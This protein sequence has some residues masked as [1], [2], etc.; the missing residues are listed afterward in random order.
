MKF[1]R[2][3]TKEAKVTKLEDSRTTRR[4]W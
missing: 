4:M 2:I 1:K 3:V